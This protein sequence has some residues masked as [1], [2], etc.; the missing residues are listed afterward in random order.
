MR[1]DSTHF[2]RFTSTHIIRSIAQKRCATTTHHQSRCRHPIRRSI[3]TRKFRRDCLSTRRRFR[4]GSPR[5]HW[6]IT[7]TRKAWRITDVQ[8]RR[9]A[10]VDTLV[11]TRRYANVDALLHTRRYAIVDTLVHTRRYAIVDTLVHTRRYAFAWLTKQTHSQP[12]SVWNLDDIH[13]LQ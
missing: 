2:L 10:I 1:I 11:H 13:A 3:G 6:L 8:T 12:T 9:Y 4:T 5:T 7:S